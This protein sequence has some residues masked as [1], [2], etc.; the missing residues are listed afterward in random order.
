MKKTGDRCM[1][2][3]LKSLLIL[4]LGTVQATGFIAA[5]DSL[6]STRDYT[7]TVPDKWKLLPPEELEELQARNY[8]GTR[9]SIHAWSPTGRN[10]VLQAPLLLAFYH[11]IP[12]MHL[13]PFA[14]VLKDEN[15]VM[16]RNGV[17]VPPVPDEATFR[18][19]YPYQNSLTYHL[20]GCVLSGNG[21]LRLK[22]LGLVKDS[23]VVRQTFLSA[24]HSVEMTEPFP[25]RDAEAEAQK[26]ASERESKSM[27]RWLIMGACILFYYLYRALL[28]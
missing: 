16:Q 1:K 17:T 27:S 7:L 4:L 3:S 23:A 26:E 13:M 24:Y 8:H 25:N 18:F 20:D 15:Q 11:E 21:I 10:K 28:T 9:N 12:A 6:F 22:M 19:Y 14:K 2:F 5:Q